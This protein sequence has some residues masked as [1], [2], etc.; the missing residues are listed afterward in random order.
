MPKVPTL[1]DS[2]LLRARMQSVHARGRITDVLLGVA[3]DVLEPFASDYLPAD[4]YARLCRLVQAS[5]DAAA[6]A[7]LTTITSDLALVAE[8]NLDIARRLQ[9]AVHGHM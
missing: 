4:E 5:V 7:A 6:E 9:R 8:A 2:S 3:L 1:T